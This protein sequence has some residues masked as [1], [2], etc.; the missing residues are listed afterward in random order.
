[1]L[2]P[3][4][5]ADDAQSL[6]VFAGSFLIKWCGF[7]IVGVDFYATGASVALHALSHITLKSSGC[8]ATHNS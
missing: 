7:A 6:L 8:V 5:A 1:M 3:K 4:P 2:D